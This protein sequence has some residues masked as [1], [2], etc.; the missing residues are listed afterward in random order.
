MEKI[1]KN[2]ER[3]FNKC[4]ILL[5]KG[6]STDYCLSK[7]KKYRNILEDY[8]N[9]AGKLKDLE[10]VEP[11]NDY[12]EKTLNRIYSL[13]EGEIDNNAQEVNISENKNFINSRAKIKSFFLKPAILFLIVFVVVSFSFVGVVFGSQSSIPNEALYPVKRA[14]EKIELIAYPGQNKGPFH[15]QFLEHRLYEANKLIET[16]FSNN[17]DL[18]GGLL[19]EIKNE[20]EQCKK[21]SYFGAK[22][23]EEMVNLINNAINKYNDKFDK[24][25]QK[26]DDQSNQDENLEYNTS[27]TNED[28]DEADE[29]IDDDA[30]EIDDD[31]EG[32][33]DIDVEDDDSDT[34]ADTTETDDDGDEVDTDDEP[35]DD[36]EPDDDSDEPDD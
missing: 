29:T 34:D 14:V 11:A 30:T 27:I 16:N 5:S 9:T 1:N 8:L 19:L 12:I 13:P 10:K 28:D 2:L 15:F 18:I 25:L 32:N 22:T 4:V 26:D 7:F 31:N 23:E 3:I 20:Y 6:Y 36:N 33:N 17:I 24:S 21:Y 35:D